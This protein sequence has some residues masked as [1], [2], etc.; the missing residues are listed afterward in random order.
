MKSHGRFKLS[1][2]DTSGRGVVERGL[3]RAALVGRNRRGKGKEAF[4]KN[5]NRKSNGRHTTRDSGRERE[6]FVR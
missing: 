6:S 2:S 4:S 5:G 3:L 1:R